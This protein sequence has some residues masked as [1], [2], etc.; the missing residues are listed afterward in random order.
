V[1]L[2]DSVLML[3]WLRRCLFYGSSDAMV[4]RR[5]LFYGSSVQKLMPTLE[6]IGHQIFWCHHQKFKILNLL[7]P[8]SCQISTREKIGHQFFWCHQ[9]KFK[10]LN[11]PKSCQC[12]ISTRKYLATTVKFRSEQ[13]FKLQ[14]QTDILIYIYY[15]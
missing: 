12:Q 6:K 8:K 9:W 11:K 4:V 15:L 5:W 3:W 7:K 14:T 13:K 2:M 10:I 1:V